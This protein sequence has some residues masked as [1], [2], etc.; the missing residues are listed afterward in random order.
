MPRVSAAAGPRRPPRLQTE[1]QKRLPRVPARHSA[2]RQRALLRQRKDDVIPLRRYPLPSRQHPES[3]LTFGI[4]AWQ[5]SRLRNPPARPPESHGTAGMGCLSPP[6][7]SLKSAPRKR[8]SRNRQANVLIH[9]LP[10]RRRAMSSAPAW[11]EPA[12][13]APRY[14]R[15]GRRR[16]LRLQSP[17]LPRPRL[18]LRAERK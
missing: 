8:H 18:A 4:P 5:E 7:G 1:G 10:A 17:I 13:K 3:S 15:Y 9:A 6:R 11:Q 2:R 14:L 12:R 16:G